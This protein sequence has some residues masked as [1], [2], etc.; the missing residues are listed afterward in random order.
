MSPLKLV[1]AA[2]VDWE[3]ELSV[4]LISPHAP[5]LLRV[6]AER[7]VDTVP[8]TGH[9]W[10]QTGGTSKVTGGSG[11]WCALS[12]KAILTS[13]ATVNDH[14]HARQEDIWFMCL[15]DWHIGG[16]S[17][18]ARAHLS[19]SKVVIASG[20]WR[21]GWKWDPTR[22]VEEVTES[23]ATL[24]SLVPAQISDF[25]R[26]SISAPRNLRLVFVGG[27]KL[28]EPLYLSARK[29]G[30]PILP[31]YGMTEVSS[32]VASA[33]LSSLGSTPSYPSLEK[34]PH[35]SLRLM[36]DGVLEVNSDSLLTGMA[37]Q[38]GGK[39]RWMD[40]KVDGWYRTSD[41]VEIHGNQVVPLHRWTDEVKILGELVNLGE[42]ESIVQKEIPNSVIVAI[43]HPRDGFEIV[44][45]ID[46]PV[47]VRVGTAESKNE[48]LDPAAFE[49]IQKLVPPFV[50][51][52]KWLVHPVP[53][54]EMGKIHR[55]EL[56]AQVASFF[57]VVES[58]RG[59]E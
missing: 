34:L 48:A 10:L 27:G 29:L 45:V 46:Q 36:N 33:S 53:R 47:A 3:S 11:T 21:E 50:K 54:S 58:S 12:K 20:R 9:V 56:S 41:R 15:P 49:R 51:F 4:A 23:Q 31:T 38:E 39:L 2:N 28:S 35:V 6:E 16:A 14:I 7:V 19:R 5:D 37:R 1:R 30:W 26:L 17:V 55:G 57:V 8:L 44:V 25:V 22:F 42:I 52:K 13:A 18:F 24:T 32:Q 43:D 59:S 40:P